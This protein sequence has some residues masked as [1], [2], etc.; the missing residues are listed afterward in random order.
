MMGRWRRDDRSMTGRRAESLLT[1]PSSKEAAMTILEDE[2]VLSTRWFA[3]E[4]YD[5]HS[6]NVTNSL[7]DRANSVHSQ[8]SNYCVEVGG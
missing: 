5:C 8:R 7:L 4:G 3:A 1:W 6:D 2:T